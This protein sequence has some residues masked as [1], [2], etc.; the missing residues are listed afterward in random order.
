MPFIPNAADAFHESQGSAR[1]TTA[2]GRTV[3][4][5]NGS[6]AGR[7]RTCPQFK[8]LGTIVG[9]NSIQVVDL[10][11]RRERSSE[12]LFHDY[13]V[14]CSPSF[15]VTWGGFDPDVSIPISPCRADDPNPADPLVNPLACSVGPSGG[16]ATFLTNVVGKDSGSNRARVAAVFCS[17][18]GWSKEN[19]ALRTVTRFWCRT[20]ARSW[21]SLLAF[22]R[23][24]N[25]TADLVTLVGAEGVFA[26]GAHLFNRWVPSRG[27]FSRG[28]G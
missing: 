3:G 19:V 9:S 15:S 4:N 14:F 5:I 6:N 7:L 25:R 12:G 8:V 11:S 1:R 21:L 28:S 17:P 16:S 13:S 20:I 26:Y 10:F 24:W 27:A 18:P 22:H 23:A 2:A